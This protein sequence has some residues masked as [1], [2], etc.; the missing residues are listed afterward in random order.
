MRVTLTVAALLSLT[1]VAAADGI[2]KREP[3][4]MFPGATVYVDNGRCS[5]GKI[6]RVTAAFKGSSRRKTCIALDR[7]EAAA[8]STDDKPVDR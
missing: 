7:R 6:L 2:L 4:S 1:G 3:R 5:D 8:P